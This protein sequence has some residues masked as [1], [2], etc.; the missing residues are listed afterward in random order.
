M[1]WR[2]SVPCRKATSEARSHP[3]S[4]P[5]DECAVTALADEGA[6]ANDRAAADEDRPNGALH[7][8]AL[9]RRVVARVVEVL[10]ADRPAGGWV[11][12]DDVGVAAD[13]DRALPIEAE[14]AGRRRR[15]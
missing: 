8:E 1:R 13:L 15:E 10:G 7:L 2:S 14:Q 3:G 9:V 4:A 12:E 6:V 5:L 11:E